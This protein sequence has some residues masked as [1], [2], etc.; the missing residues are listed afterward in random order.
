MQDKVI[1]M[2]DFMASM[3]ST[4]RESVK[5]A[6]PGMEIPRRLED[7][8]IPATGAGE[9]VLGT[10]LPDETELAIIVSAL[11]DYMDSMERKVS[12]ASLQLA[13]QEISKSSSKNEVDLEA[14][15]RRLL[16]DHEI[17]LC[18]LFQCEQRLKTYSSALYLSVYERLGN[19]DY[20]I[21]VRAGHKIVTT[22]RR[23][24]EL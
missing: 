7:C 10:L 13:G 6:F 4:A 8:D 18:N 23:I 17:D 24:P 9:R 14:L 21:A 3:T 15:N 12:G 16:T 11:D 22:Q 20:R 5:K 2:V 1:N 19:W